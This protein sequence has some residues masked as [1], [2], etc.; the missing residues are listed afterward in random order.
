MQG[1]TLDIANK[2]EWW[3][4]QYLSF[5]QQRLGDMRSWRQVAENTWDVV[6]ESMNL[7][8]YYN[9]IWE[10]EVVIPL[11][12]VLIEIYEWR[13]KWF[14]NYN[15]KNDWQANSR[16]LQPAKYALQHFLDWADNNSFWEDN[17]LGEL[18]SLR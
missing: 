6:D 8:S 14:I 2:K 4:A 17:F 7:V 5:F 15:I 3:K 12:Q 16:E 9:N 13:T 18:F 10:L 1:S 11:D